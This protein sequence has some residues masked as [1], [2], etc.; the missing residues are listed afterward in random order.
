M[1]KRLNNS[2]QRKLLFNS[3][4]HIRTRDRNIDGLPY[5]L[6]RSLSKAPFSE[7]L[8]KDLKVRLKEA[9][10]KIAVLD[11]GAG[12]GRMLAEIVAM[13]PGKIDG[14]ALTL[15]KTVERTNSEFINRV[16]QKVGITAKHSTK[17]NVIYDC[18]GEDYYLPKQLLKKS[19]S[20]SIGLLRRG[21]VLHTII[22]IVP[23]ENRTNFEPSEARVFV[24]S[25][26]KRPGIKVSTKTLNKRFGF[27]EYVDL[28]IRIEKK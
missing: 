7:R 21:G 18:Y 5:N 28:M 26:K 13:S 24:A 1:K 15:S 22:A 17:Y 10:G 14:T 6:N 4:S 8:I 16:M 20:K 23:K 25:L 12:T 3:I 9:R 11:K 2:K 19:L 27:S